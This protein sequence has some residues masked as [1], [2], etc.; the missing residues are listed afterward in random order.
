M[1]RNSCFA[2][3]VMLLA[4]LLAHAQDHPLLT[5][6]PGSRV[7]SN[8]SK[9]FAQYKL[10]TAFDQKTNTF[11]G[12]TLEGRVTR[13]IYGNPAQRSPL[14]IFRNYESALA[15]AGMERLFQCGSEQ[16]GPTFSTSAWNR[17]NGVMAFSG[18]DS[19]YL[20]GK[21]KTANSEA[22]VALMV[23]KQRT[24]IDIVERKAMDAGLVVVNA[25]ALA[26]GLAREGKVSIYGIYFDTGKA[27]L[28]PESKPALDEI[29]LLLRQKPELKLHVVGHTDNTG[30]FATN[31]QLSKDRAAAVVAALTNEYAIAL[32]RLAAHGV[33]PLA[34]AATNANEDGRSKNRRVEL[35]A[36]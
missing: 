16:C 23:G 20:A 17:Y 6:Y 32:H 36:Q 29:A 25:E 24:Q 34:P 13:L 4:P 28:K 9:E 5:R 19:H 27:E 22:F 33:G 30:T 35:V 12:P 1:F 15:Q 7:E 21:I 11:S 31:L 26:A 2:F 18:K 8:T 14:E 10:V 3:V